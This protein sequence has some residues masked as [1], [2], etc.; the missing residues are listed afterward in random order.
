M[1]YIEKLLMN[2]SRLLIA[3]DILK[4]NG[5]LVV[6]NTPVCKFAGEKDPFNYC[7]FCGLLFRRVIIHIKNRHKNEIKEIEESDKT[8]QLKEYE[9]LMRKGNFKWN[10][11]KAVS[12]GFGFIIPTRKAPYVFKD[13]R[14]MIH[15]TECY[16]FIERANYNRHQNRCPQRSSGAPKT[17]MEEAKLRQVEMYV[18]KFRFQNEKLIA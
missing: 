12:S 14:D 1:L 10:N 16:S 9:Q 2:S 5:P 7:V 3:T 17:S 6:L 4:Y 13:H 11:A 15:C 18:C 8:K